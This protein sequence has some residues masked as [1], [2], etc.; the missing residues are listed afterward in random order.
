[1]ACAGS[2]QPSLA[3]NTPLVLATNVRS[4]VCRAIGT[5]SHQAVICAAQQHSTA[6]LN[7]AHT[8]LRCCCKNCCSLLQD[9][10]FDRSKVDEALADLPAMPQ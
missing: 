6:W 7:T 9:L 4:Y 3:G 2:A 5:S 10:D 1:V 8:S